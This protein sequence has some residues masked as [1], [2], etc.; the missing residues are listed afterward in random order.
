MSHVAPCL[1]IVFQRMVMI[2][3]KLNHNKLIRGRRIS[4]Y[5]TETEIVYLAKVI[6][7]IFQLIGQGHDP[8]NW[9]WKTP[10]R[11]VILSA[12]SKVEDYE[13]ENKQ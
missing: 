13:T 2:N 7:D 3:L 10:I 8:R 5:Q 6:S 11:L 1:W 9:I 12:N 4:L